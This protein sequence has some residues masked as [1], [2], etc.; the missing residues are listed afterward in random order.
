MK[1]STSRGDVGSAA[2]DFL[3]L[4]AYFANSMESVEY[5]RGCCRYS[6]WTVPFGEVVMYLP[7]QR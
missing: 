3:G 5:R 6:P 7:K 4:V 2:G 1:D